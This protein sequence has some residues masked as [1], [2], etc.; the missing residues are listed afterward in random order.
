MNEVTECCFD[1]RITSLERKMYLLGILL[2][3]FGTCLMYEGI[4]S[5]W[6]K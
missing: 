3:I 5:A 6:R 2:L 4:A 1:V